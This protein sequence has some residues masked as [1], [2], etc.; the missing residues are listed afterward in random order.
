MSERERKPKTIGAALVRTGGGRLALRLVVDGRLFVPP[1]GPH[2]ADPQAFFGT[3][4]AAAEAVRAWRGLAA[5][6]ALEPAGEVDDA[7]FAPP[8]DLRRAFKAL[9]LGRSYRAHAV[10]LGNAPVERPLT[11]AKFPECFVGGG[12]A[13][14]IPPDA[15]GK[16]DHEAELAIV[17]GDDAVDLPDGAGRSRIAGYVVAND[18]TLRAVQAAAKAAGHPWLRA[19]NFPGSMPVGPWLT[20]AWAVEDPSSLVVRCVVDGDL[21]QSARVADMTWDVGRVVEELSRLW[22]LRA[23][24]VISTGTPAGVAGLAPGQTCVVEVA[25]DAV[26]LGRLVTRVAAT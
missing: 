3:P 13:V 5:T 10:E 6:G 15:A 20:P 11:F 4:S 7:R 26:S 12:D 23:G 2:D 17:I 14:S 16:M 8:F 24:D 19:K 21:R 22:P 1:S 25:N 18:L 9:A